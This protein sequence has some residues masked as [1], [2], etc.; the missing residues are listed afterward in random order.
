MTITYLEN[1]FKELMTF[2]MIL[3]LKML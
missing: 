3:Y 1:I 2:E